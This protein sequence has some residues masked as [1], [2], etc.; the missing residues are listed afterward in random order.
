MSK[1]L[2]A[3]QVELRRLTN[4]ISVDARQYWSSELTKATRFLVEC[5]DALTRCQSYVRESE[6]RPCTEEKKRLAK[7]KDRR[8]LCERMV[9]LAAAAAT[10]WEREQNKNHAKTQRLVDMVEADLLVASNHLQGHIDLIEDYANVSSG[11][12]SREIGDSAPG[13][14]DSQDGDASNQQSQEQGDASN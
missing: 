11:G 14:T 9:R 10:A 7:A 13:A 5:Q 12:P 3:L 4:W 8:Q 2:E 1:E 6:K